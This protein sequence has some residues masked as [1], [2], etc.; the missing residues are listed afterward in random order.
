MPSLIE[1]S[2]EVIEELSSQNSS[3]LDQVNQQMLR[4]EHENITHTEPQAIEILDEE[5]E[6]DENFREDH[7]LERPLSHEANSDLILKH[8]RYLKVLGQ[9]S[10]SDKQVRDKWDEWKENIEQ[11]CWDEVRVLPSRR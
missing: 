11:L 6:E 9:A 2:L 4:H 3:T 8:S 1:R 7:E 5:A 10:E